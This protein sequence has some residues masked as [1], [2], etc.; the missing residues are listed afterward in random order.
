MSARYCRS[1]NRGA[2]RIA[3]AARPASTWRIGGAIEEVRDH[4]GSA[5]GE[6]R[7]HERTGERPDDVAGADEGA[8]DREAEAGDQ[9]DQAQR[10]IRDHQAVDAAPGDADEVPGDDDRP[11]HEVVRELAV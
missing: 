6:D 7:H 11:G 4:G 9:H 3:D 2:T 5:E 10:G 1:M 8:A